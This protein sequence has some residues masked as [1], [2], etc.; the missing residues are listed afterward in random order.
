MRES[1]LSTG[2]RRR[3]I[4]QRV[5]WA[6]MSDRGWNT[7]GYPNDPAQGDPGDPAGWPGRPDQGQP[8]A[9][10]G[11]GVQNAGREPEHRPLGNQPLQRVDIEAY[12]APRFT[13]GWL[14]WVLF[15]AIIAGV[16]IG[17]TFLARPAAVAPT[18]S[19]TSPAA[20][21]TSSGPGLPFT[22]PSD[23]DSGGRWE[24]VSEQW[25]PGGVLLSVR[26]WADRGTISY[27]FL[28]FQ[29]NGTNVIDPAPSP[30]QPELTRGTLAEG[31]STTGYVFLPIQ[32]APA[33]LILTTAT[34]RQISAL[35]V[36]S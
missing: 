28:A 33:T 9:G 18:A 29:N 14:L 35:P 5:P 8:T 25:Q 20:A 24:V 34:G 36:K 30:R 7:N 22:M 6:A 21:P 11:Q 31:D 17:A 32:R 1:S 13:K 3:S 16:V 2:P 27:G 23:P 26:L 12:S 15:A 10:Q 4:R 19:P